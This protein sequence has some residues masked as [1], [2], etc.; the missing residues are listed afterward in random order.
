MV[1]LQAEN[2]TGVDIL[3]EQTYVSFNSL[4]EDPV[5]GS[6]NNMS[7]VETFYVIAQHHAPI[8]LKLSDPDVLDVQIELSSDSF[9]TGWDLAIRAWPSMNVV[10]WLEVYSDPMVPREPVRWHRDHVVF[11]SAE[12]KVYW[13]IYFQNPSLAVKTRPFPISLAPLPL[14]A[15]PQFHWWESPAVGGVGMIAAWVILLVGI[16]FPWADRTHGLIIGVALTL[17]TTS[18]LYTLACAYF[19]K[20]ARWR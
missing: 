7:M 15:L 9:R 12:G 3:D 14:R 4:L 13:E 18:G 20:E 2:V 6:W 16:I 11:M 8:N 17:L 1:A 10:S 19:T 5:R